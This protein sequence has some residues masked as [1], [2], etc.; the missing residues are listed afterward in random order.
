MS[1]ERKKGI[2]CQTLFTE[3]FQNLVAQHTINLNH[4]FHP[5][6]FYNSV[7]TLNTVLYTFLKENGFNYHELRILVIIS[8][9]LVCDLSL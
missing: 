6:H 3:T 5:S 9:I 7:F 1:E 2:F 4:S 8:F